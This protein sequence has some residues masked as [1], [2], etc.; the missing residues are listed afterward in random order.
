[1]F[2]LLICIIYLCIGHEE[3]VDIEKIPSPLSKGYFQGLLKTELH[4]LRLIWRQL[5]LFVEEGSRT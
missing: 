4:I 1:M 2:F 5:I 3:N